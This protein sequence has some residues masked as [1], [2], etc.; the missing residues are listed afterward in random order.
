MCG[1]LEILLETDM[2]SVEVLCFTEHWLNYHKIHAI[3]INHFTLSNAFCRYRPLF[4][5]GVKL[6]R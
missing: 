5:M 2:N 6:G 1:E 3:N 4:C